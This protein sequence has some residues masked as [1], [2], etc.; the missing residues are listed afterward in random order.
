[1][2]KRVLLKIVCFL[3]VSITALVITILSTGLTVGYRVNYDGEEI[4]VIAKSSVF[5]KAVSLLNSMVNG[6]N[7]EID[8]K[9]P[10]FNLTLAVSNQMLSARKLADVIIDKSDNVTFAQALIVNGETVATVE[11]FDAQAYIDSRLAAYNIDGADNFS[12]FAED[13]N[14]ESGYR[15][16][17]GFYRCC[18]FASGKNGID[19]CYKC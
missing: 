5:D 17:F 6:E 2:K 15:H 8:V 14:I 4:A 12:E 9:K 3:L 1:M 13:V 18:R 10:E 16:A 7:T 11:N 19:R